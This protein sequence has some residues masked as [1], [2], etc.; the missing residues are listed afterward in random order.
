MFILK[1][2]HD[3]FPLIDSLIPSPM[4]INKSSVPTNT[5]K[6]VN[7]NHHADIL[8]FP[9][10]NN[11]PRLGVVGGTPNP[12]KSKLVKTKIPPLIR[13]GKKVTTEI[14]LLGNMCLMIICQSVNP[15]VRAALT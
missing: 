12:K 15:S 8:S 13:N 14:K 6:V 1:Y 2:T 9:Y 7:D 3:D 11:S 4:N 5:K 10:A